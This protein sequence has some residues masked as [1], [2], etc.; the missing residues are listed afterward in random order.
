MRVLHICSVCSHPRN[1]RSLLTR[2]ELGASMEQLH[3]I[4]RACTTPGSPGVPCEAME[5]DALITARNAD[6]HPGGLKQLGERVHQ[7]LSLLALLQGL[8]QEAHMGAAAAV[9]GAYERL[10]DVFPD[11]FL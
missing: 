6:I 1:F 9:L 5:L 8:D 4:I 10:R 2:P 7:A 3:S 11:A